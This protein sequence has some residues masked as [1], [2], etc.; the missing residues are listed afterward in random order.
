MVKN[1]V[2]DLGNV[3]LDF[4]SDEIIADYVKDEKLHQQISENIFNSKE[5]ILLDRGEITA[6]EAT[7]RFI[8]RIP[9]KEKLVR[10]IMD[11]WKHYLTPIQVNVEV[12][13]NIA[14]K[15]INLYVL[16]NF[17]KEAFEEVYEKYDFFNHFDGMI[18]SYREKTVKPER[19]IYEKLI[20]RYNLK[21]DTTLFID[22]SERNIE[23]A[24]KLGFKTIHFNDNMKLS[25]SIT[26]YIR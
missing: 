1:V 22:D 18:I 14:Q 16:S 4:N 7:N 21:P 6:K 9:D 11:N 13:N 12:L 19:K 5:W 23:A 10:E 8:K 26:D 3:L 24:K 17:H 20:N 15:P 2:F 25:N